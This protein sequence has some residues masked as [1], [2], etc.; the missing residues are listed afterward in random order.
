[1]A[2]KE[3]LKGNYDG[4]LQQYEDAVKLFYFILRGKIS[5]LSFQAE[6]SYLHVSNSQRKDFNLLIAFNFKFSFIRK[7]RFYLNCKTRFLTITQ[8]V[9]YTICR[10][11]FSFF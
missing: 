6:L 4:A 5:G 2:T 3:D 8:S 9:I 1:M 10:N 7:V 11:L